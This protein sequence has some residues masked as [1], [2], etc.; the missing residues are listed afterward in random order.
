MDGGTATVYGPRAWEADEEFAGAPVPV[1]DALVS[2]DGGR[3][4]RLLD[5]PPA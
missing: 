1:N 2:G 3:G 5:R 4:Q